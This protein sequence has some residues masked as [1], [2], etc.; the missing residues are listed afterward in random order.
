MVE[1]DDKPLQDIT[2]LDLTTFVSGGF[3]TMMLANHGADV[4][5]IERPTVGD[6]SRHSG[7]PFV[8]VED[9]SGPGRV[10][11]EE[12]ESPYF[13]TVNY[14]KRSIELNLKTDEGLHVLFDLLESAD[15]IIEN[16]RPGT[17]E[18]LGIDYDSVRSINKNVIYCSIS[19]FGDSG[20]WSSRPGYDLLIQ[21]M[22]GIIDVTGPEDGAGVKVGLPQT[23]LITSMWAAFGIVG[24]LF[25][26]ERTGKGEKV[27]LGM[28]DATLPWLTKQAGKVFADETPQRM[29]TKDPVL[30]PY[31]TY[32]TADGH[33]AVA[34]GNQKLFEELCEAIGR[35]ELA[36]DPRFETNAKRVEHM[37]ALE[38]ELSE[39]FS[40]KPT[41]EW[42][43]SLATESGL[44]V[45]PVHSVTEA[46]CNEQVESRNVIT[47]LEHSAVGEINVIEHP[48]N[49][50][51]AT[52]GFETPPPLLGE[53][54]E[55]VL[56]EL[57]Y[58]ETE[59]ER[60]QD[61][62]AIPTDY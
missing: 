26:R 30:A 32:P 22:S 36:S 38:G 14:D 56:K 9:Y 8:P 29:G 15:V 27:E 24:A 47:Q 2:V 12:G 51:E 49:F 45:G 11:T 55:A 33:L 34:C 57:G 59:I 18:K 13:W 7:P 25:R 21:G 1:A 28:L 52:T 53:H 37:E 42:V 62:G 60:L 61:D 48:L 50:E 40:E 31:Q 6:D 39:V 17:T 5:K 23:D 44:P 3:A 19:A 10:A 41:D 58:S 35:P 54:T 43:K 16:F 46:L 4:I 20:P